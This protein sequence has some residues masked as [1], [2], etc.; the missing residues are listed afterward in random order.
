[1]QVKFILILK[2][3][4]ISGPGHPDCATR[5]NGDLLSIFVITWK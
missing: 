5:F 3:K 4:F 1:M 2:I